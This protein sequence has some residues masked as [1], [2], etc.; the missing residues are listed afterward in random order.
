MNI[1][2]SIPKDFPLCNKS[3]GDDVCVKR[4]VKVRLLVIAT[5]VLIIVILLCLSAKHYNQ[6]NAIIT[7]GDNSYKA[8][9]VGY[10]RYELVD[11]HELVGYMG[12]ND[13]NYTYTV[14]LGSEQFEKTLYGGVNGR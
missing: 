6:S 10:G 4:V 9:R 7:I 13:R 1:A 8:I 12:T 14:S 11:G 5:C 3:D 2:R